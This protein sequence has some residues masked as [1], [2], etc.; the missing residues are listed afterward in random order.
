MKSFVFV[1]SVL[2]LSQLSGAAFRIDR[3]DPDYLRYLG[4]VQVVFSGIKTYIS[5]EGKLPKDSQDLVRSPYLAVPPERIENPYTRKPMVFPRNPVLGD[6][7]WNYEK[8]QLTLRMKARPW[9]TR[10]EQ[11]SEMVYDPAIV[12]KWASEAR[13]YGYGH[14]KFSYVMSLPRED[15]W[16]YLSCFQV[17]Y[18]LKELAFNPYVKGLPSKIEGLNE[19]LRFRQF[20]I[21]TIWNPYENREAKQVTEPSPGDY[22]LKW[23]ETPRKG[24][25]PVLYCFNKNKEPLSP[26][27]KATFEGEQGLERPQIPE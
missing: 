11:L 13:Q 5:Y 24:R 23:A 20:F 8:D 9:G 3:L 21:Y 25:I 1:T 10:R 16:L 27:L 19:D 12:S 18:A 14:D 6:I 15:R 26:S 7:A 2:M 22:I 17:S 4:A